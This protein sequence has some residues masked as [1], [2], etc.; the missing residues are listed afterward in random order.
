MVG[1]VGESEKTDWDGLTPKEEQLE[2]IVK[3]K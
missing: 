2:S 1:L 3:D